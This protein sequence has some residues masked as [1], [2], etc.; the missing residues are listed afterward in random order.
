MDRLHLL[1]EIAAS[2]LPIPLLTMEETLK[3]QGE[4]ESGGDLI[5]QSRSR[6]ETHP[7]KPHC[8]SPSHHPHLGWGMG[9]YCSRC[10]LEDLEWDFFLVSEN[11]KRLTLPSP[12]H[13]SK[14]S[15]TPGLGDGEMLQQT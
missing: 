8:M 2:F 1:H 10:A 5:E 14:P 3:Q 15:P 13:V 11:E 6:K 12:L 9:K 7:S 4:S